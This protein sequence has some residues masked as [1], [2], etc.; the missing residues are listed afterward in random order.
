MLRITRDLCRISIEE[1][2]MQEANS[3]VVDQPESNFLSWHQRESI[4]AGVQVAQLK[5]LTTLL[6]QLHRTSP[7]KPVVC[8]GKYSD[9]LQPVEK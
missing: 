1:S 2:N 9:S 6:R 4:A 5:T 3:H 8:P 7:E